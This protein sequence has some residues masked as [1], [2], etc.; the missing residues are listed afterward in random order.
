MSGAMWEQYVDQNPCGNWDL[1]YTW[2]IFVYCSHVRCVLMR[3][4]IRSIFSLDL[5][6]F[7]SIYTA[8]FCFPGSLHLGVTGADLWCLYRAP[9]PGP[10]TGAC[11]QA[12]QW[13]DSCLHNSN[14]S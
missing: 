7:K 12:C 13:S 4:A 14:H 9:F 8:Y 2:Q 3:L 11:R 5:L 6:F 10:T 1:V